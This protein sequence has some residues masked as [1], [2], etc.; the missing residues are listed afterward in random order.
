MDG[1]AEG[2]EVKA[3]FTLRDR[4]LFEVGKAGEREGF[5]SR[6][7]LPFAVPMLQDMLARKWEIYGYS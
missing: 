5:G 4:R 1:R 2:E 7:L 3:V 6:N